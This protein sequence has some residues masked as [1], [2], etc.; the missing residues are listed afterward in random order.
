MLTTSMIP[1]CTGS[2]P[3]AIATG[4]RI[5]AMIRTMAEGSIT[6]PIISRSTLTT[7]RK[8]TLPRPSET[9]HSDSAC[10][11]CSE[12]RMKANITALVMM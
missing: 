5:G 1:K 11:I 2:T 3:S 7:R 6:I 9:I 10:G 12:V 4:Y 8:P